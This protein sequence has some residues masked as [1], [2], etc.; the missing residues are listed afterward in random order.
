MSKGPLTEYR[1]GVN[2]GLEEAAQ[3][4]DAYAKEVQS[5]H[6]LSAAREIAR[7]IREQKKG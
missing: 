2:A 4:A 5:G 7:R 3:V 6:W 1:E